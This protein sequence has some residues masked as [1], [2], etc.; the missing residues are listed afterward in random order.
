MSIIGRFRRAFS[1]ERTKDNVPSNDKLSTLTAREY[2]AF[3]LLL[4]GYTLKFC[5]EKMGVKYSTANTYQNSIYKKL[6]VKKR[7]RLIIEYKD[8]VRSDKNEL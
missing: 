4:E 2:E 6:G 7:A 1:P 5:A 3:L 8:Y